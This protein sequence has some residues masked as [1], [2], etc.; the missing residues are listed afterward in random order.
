MRTRLF[1]LAAVGLAAALAACDNDSL[2]PFKSAERISPAV[3]TGEQLIAVVI[4]STP[5]GVRVGGKVRLESRLD[6]NSGGSL[7]GRRWTN[8][9]TLDP[10]VAVVAANGFVTG[11]DNGVARIVA[12]VDELA[13][14]LALP[15]GTSRDSSSIEPVDSTVVDSTGTGTDSTGTDSS[16]TGAPA[17]TTK[18]DTAV[19]PPPPPPT[20]SSPVELP[21]VTVDTRLVAPTGRRLLVRA[22]GLLQAALD[23]ARPGDVIALEQGAEFVGHYRLRRKSGDEW[24]TIRTAGS[25]ATLPAP[26][27]RMTPTRAASANLPRILTPDISP[28]I[29]TDSGAHHYRIIGVE[30]GAAAAVTSQSGLVTLGSSGSYQSQL[31]EVPHHLILDRVWVHGRPSLY[32]KRCVTLNSAHSAVIDSYLDDCHADG[33]DSQAIVGWN[34]PG[35]FHIENNYLAG[36]GE[37]IM[38]GGADPTIPNLLPS[39]I[40]IRNNFVH[41]PAAWKDRWSVKNSLEFKAGQRVL[42]EGNIFDGNWADGQVGFMWNIKSSNQ[43]GSCTWCVTQ[44]VTLR[45]NILRNTGGGVTVSGAEGMGPAQPTNHIAIMHN[46]MERV[47]MEGTVYVGIG[48]PFQVSAVHD[49]TIDH[50]LIDTPNTSSL[51]M[52]ANNI[53]RNFRFTNNAAYKGAYGLHGIATYGAASYVAGNGLV[54]SSGTTI[55]SNYG[56]GNVLVRTLADAKQVPGVD[57]L[58]A[59]ASTGTVASMTSEALP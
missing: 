47:D 30:I 32:M 52:F 35:P 43:G 56:P 53:G 7:D 9:T 57:G 38:F 18:T 22:G 40:V 16:S 58:A 36:A 12:S 10:A 15:V 1:P 51:L 31:S 20:A 3:R 17:D 29:G 45:Y 46:V 25:D 21:R 50:N 55:Y 34:G 28:A 19:T 54:A 48:R 13:D 6:F 44:H 14:T 39:D 49:L 42:V 27:T 2:A 8:W 41:K 4:T 59:G 11:R 5:S 23:S 26:G 33:Q 24:I 37:N